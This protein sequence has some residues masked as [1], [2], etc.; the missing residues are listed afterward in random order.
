MTGTELFKHAFG[1]IERN[2]GTA[3]Q[4]S[5]VLFVISLILQFVPSVLGMSDFTLMFGLGMASYLALTYLPSLVAMILGA[6]VAVAWH[7]YVLLEE[8]PGGWIPIF[9]GREVQNY[10]L[11]MILLFLIYALML[12]PIFLVGGL[13]IPGIESGRNPSALGITLFV[14]LFLVTITVAVIVFTRLSTCLVARAVSQ[15][16]SLSGAWSATRGSSGPIV[17]CMLIMMGVMIAFG[18]IVSILV[19]VIGSVGMIVAVPFYLLFTWALMF[20]QISLMTT[21]YGH[22]V[23]GRGLVA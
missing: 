14:V 8:N 12:F 9:H 6:W 17:I 19:F 18:A 2:F 13:A 16:L 23:E 22:Y 10:V 7:R 3:L 4:I 1:M 20:F 11:W 21:L 15:P 5:A